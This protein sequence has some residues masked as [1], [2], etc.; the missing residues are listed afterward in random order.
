MLSLLLLVFLVELGAHLV[1]TIG[2]ATI[3]NLLW[4]LY[5]A[6]PTQTSKQAAEN[7][8]LQKDYLTIRRDL[9]ATS[10]QDQFAKWAK[11]RRQHDKML[12]QLEKMKSSYE[13]SKSK[14]ESSIGI[15]RWTATTGLKF[16]LPF[17][18]AKQPMFWLPQGWFPYYVEWVLSFPRAP[19]GSVSIAS[20]QAACTGM[21][22]L[23]SDTV[24][25]ILGLLFGAKVT[26]EQPFEGGTEKETIPKS[27]EAKSKKE[28]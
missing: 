11:L 8:K 15:V 19:V 26:P 27:Q 20:W 18:Y 2:A 14:F 6:L 21:V 17:W 24:A 1:N 28:S 25:A 3:N 5:L 23:A 9:N 22:L 12:E 4:N 7:K 10:S 13:A 16:I